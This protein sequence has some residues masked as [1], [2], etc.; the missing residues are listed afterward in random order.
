MILQQYENVAA[1]VG[2]LSKEVNQPRE[3]TVSD[4][5]LNWEL[6]L[7]T[8][9]GASLTIVNTPRTQSGLRAH[10]FSCAA[11]DRTWSLTESVHTRRA[12]HHRAA[13]RQLV[14][15]GVTL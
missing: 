2:K 13:H 6:K 5:S 4:L 8:R 11:G 1:C 15:C 9:I 3:Q 14:Q 12:R 7:D 10:L